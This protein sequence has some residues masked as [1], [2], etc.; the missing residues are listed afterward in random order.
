[1]STEVLDSP[2]LN[3]NRNYNYS[4]FSDF[5]RDD[6][7]YIVE[8]VEANTSILDLGCGN[9]T[10]IQKL[11][12]EKNVSTK[13]V[14]LS[15]SGVKVCKEKGLDVIQGRI[16]E[17]LPFGENEFDFTI[18]H[19]TIQ[20]V[21][22]PEVLLNEMKRISK[23]QIIS[24]PNFAFYKNR[25]DLFFNGRMP[26]PML[27]DYNWFNTGHIHQFSTRDFYQLLN[28]VDGFEVKRINFI[29]SNSKIKNFVARKI[30]NLFMQFPIFYLSKKS[31]NE[32][33]R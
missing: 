14:E 13:G 6:Y 16:D 20:M 29:K 1:M 25:L 2:S 7:K 11:I 24:F 17:H 12:K 3:D 4:G 33:N 27:F 31:K 8:L 26:K 10:L 23:Y 5:E 9:G 15:E 18:C 22:Y 32:S 28:V 30:P 21:M 19:I